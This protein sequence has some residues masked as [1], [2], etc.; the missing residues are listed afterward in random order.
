MTVARTPHS[1][2]SSKVTIRLGHHATIGIPPVLK[3]PRL[4]R[5]RRE[6]RAEEQ[7][8]TAPA[9]GNPGTSTTLCR[10]DCVVFERLG[11]NHGN[12]GIYAP[13]AQCAQ[14]RAVPRRASDRDR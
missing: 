5:P 2:V 3:W 6:P 8:D 10:G 7:T 14:R 1:I 12:L 11:G 13:G 4:P 9:P